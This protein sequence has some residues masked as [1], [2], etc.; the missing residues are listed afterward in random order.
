MK[1]KIISYFMIIIFLTLSLVMVGF[2]V[3]ATYYYYQSIANTFQQQA[4]SVSPVWARETDFSGIKLMDY[5]DDIIKQYE[6]KGSQLQLLKRDGKLI[7]SSTGFNEGTTYYVDPSVL[8]LKT[9]YK[10]EKN[11]YSGE[12]IMAVYTPLIF[13]G[14]TVGVLRYVVSLTKIDSMIMHLIGIGIII[15]V[16]VAVIVLLVSLK[17]GNSIVRPLNDIIE[18]TQKMP[19]DK[20][21]KRIKEIYPNELGEMA[22]MLNYM[23]DEILKT[24]RF[25]N[26]FISSVTHELRTPLTGIKGWIETI[27]APHD[28]SDEELKFGLGI[29]SD[30][31]ER[32]IVLVEDLLDFSR[33]QSNRIELVTASVNVDKIINE[34]IFTLKQKSEKKGIRLVAQTIPITITAD[35]NKLKQVV[36]NILDNAINFSYKDS[37]IN[38]IQTIN[39]DSVLIQIINVGIGIK[40]ENLEHIMKSFYKIDPKSAGSGLGLA[41]SRSI[42][43]N[44]GGTLQIESEYGKG[45]TVNISLPLEGIAVLHQSLE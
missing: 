37:I 14:Q 24:D 35:G 40:K 23:A 7:Q 26:D 6:V 22:K 3:A 45:T 44:H 32:L 9:V 34:V 29:I 33:Y 25:K 18:F 38:I 21:R 19:E 20:Y 16:V 41:I 2:G 31:S 17:L 36:F 5:S 12:K 27:Q 8:T 4:E 30:E 1:R 11:K 42:V 10:T 15:C 28:L 13:E 43:D 39:Q